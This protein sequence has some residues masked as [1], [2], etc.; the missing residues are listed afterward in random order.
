MSADWRS[1]YRDFLDLFGQG[2]YQRALGAACVALERAELGDP[3]D[4]YEL[5]TSLGAVASLY[6][7][8]GL[9]AKAMPLYERA[10][11][12]DEQAHGRAHPA[13]ATS[14]NNLASLYDKMGEFA[15]AAPLYERALGLAEHGFGAGHPAV[16]SGVLTLADCYRSLGREGDAERL[17]ERA[18]ALGL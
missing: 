16:V 2:D 10:L 3:P 7:H 8:L 9:P 13:V 11:T 18:A 15:K 5:V 12:V 6:V 14:L 17:E 4:P 1:L